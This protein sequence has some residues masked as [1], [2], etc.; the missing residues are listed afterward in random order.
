MSDE[1]NNSLGW[2]F[3]PK[4]KRKETQWQG[5]NTRRKRDAMNKL[6]HG[7]KKYRG[8]R[9]HVRPATIKGYGMPLE[10]IS[11]EI[12]FGKRKPP[13]RGIPANTPR[14]TLQRLAIGLRGKIRAIYG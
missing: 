4:S 1:I 11:Y 13:L 12:I 7:G 3:K 10:I 9:E 8:K 5:K 14:D 2:I 6:G